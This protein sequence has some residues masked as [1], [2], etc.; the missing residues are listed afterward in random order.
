MV[1]NSIEL[2]INF[3]R[4]NLEHLRDLEI[5]RFNVDIKVTVFTLRIVTALENSVCHHPL[6]SNGFCK[7][8]ID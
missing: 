6:F 2:N 3:I 5:K 7:R 8:T 4:M 1:T